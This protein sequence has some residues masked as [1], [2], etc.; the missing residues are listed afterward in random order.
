MAT[1]SSLATS[2]CVSSCVPPRSDDEEKASGRRK[3][4]DAE[5]LSAG[6]RRPLAINTPAIMVQTCPRCQRA[7][8]HEAVFCYFDGVVLRQGVAG[9]ALPAQ[10]PQEFI[11]PS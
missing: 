8:P 11:F 5:H 9:V 2:C 10:L 1:A 3:P 7:N 6:L 4:V